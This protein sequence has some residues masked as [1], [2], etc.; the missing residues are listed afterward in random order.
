MEPS[1]AI[2]I[3]ETDLRHL[4]EAVLSKNDGT[5]WIEE[6]L[7]QEVVE[8][9]KGRLR[10]EVKR[11]SPATVP[12]ALVSYTHL[13]ELRKIIE[14]NWQ[15]FAVAL[16]E[17]RDFVVLMDRVED[18]RNAPAH[19]RELLPYEK[20]M[21]EGIAG[22][23]RTQVTRYMSSKYQDARDY[24]VI[25]SIRDSFGNASADLSSTQASSVETGLVLRVGDE[26]IFECRAWDPQGRELTWQWGRVF[27]S[28]GSAITG[29]EVSLPWV[30]TEKDVGA[31][32]QIE[33]QVLSSGPYHRHT[34]Y[35]HRVTFVYAVEPPALLT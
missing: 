6:H 25:E 24:P 21:L 10:E 30:V 4:A 28:Q 31:R 12:S 35:D 7:E 18:F 27:A 23:V 3:V 16:G 5:E 22:T 29:S 33:I 19:S 32:L 2:A 9:L 20:S 1:A 13:F 26:V 8:R 14:K 34:Q 15:E 11:R 17:K